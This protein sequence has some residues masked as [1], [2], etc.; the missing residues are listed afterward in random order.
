MPRSVE[1]LWPLVLRLELE[2]GRLDPG[3]VQLAA[4]AHRSVFE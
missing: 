2:I 4:A 3:D 1:L